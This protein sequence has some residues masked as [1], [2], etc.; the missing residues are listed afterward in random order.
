MGRKLVCY[1]SVILVFLVSVSFLMPVNTQAVGTPVVT[2]AFDPGEDVQTAAVAPGDSGLVSFP[3]TV[4]AE[5]AAGSTVQDVVVTLEASTD[6]GWPAS[7]EPETVTLNPGTEEA[8]FIATVSVPL[9]T[10]WNVTGTLTV[11]GTAM[12]Y[13]GALRYNVGSISGAILIDQYYQFSIGC[14][15]PYKQC[16]PNSVLCYNLTIINEGNGN[17]KFATE[18]SNLEYL[19]HDSFTVTVGTPT[20]E[21]QGNNYGLVPIMVKTPYSEDSVGVY[22]IEVKVSSMQDNT[23]NTQPQTFT[24]TTHIKDPAS[25]PGSSDP[26]GSDNGPEPGIEDEET[27][28]DFNFDMQ[29]GL[30]IALV[31]II[32]VIFAIWRMGVSTEEK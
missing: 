10:S 9:E 3:G 19:V 25:I 15:E 16:C 11:S 18:I 22:E 2:L 28:N 1:S 5:L 29:F 17:D 4:S 13:P 12:A 27:E 24:L 8:A 20:I 7:I 6:T 14:S 21:L 26:D 31:V 23:G 32:L 30:I